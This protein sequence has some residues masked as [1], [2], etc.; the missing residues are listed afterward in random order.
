[1]GYMVRDVHIKLARITPH[2]ILKVTL[3]NIGTLLSVRLMPWFHVQLHH[4]ICCNDFT[5]S[6]GCTWLCCNHAI[7]SACCMR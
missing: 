4:A 5:I 3:Q 7:I 1:M 6:A 2:V